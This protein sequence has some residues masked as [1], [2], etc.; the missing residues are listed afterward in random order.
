MD[1]FSTPGLVN[2]FGVSSSP[3]N[4]IV[5][6]KRPLSSMCL[7]IVIDG[8]GDV[9]LAIGSAGGSRIVTAVA[10]VIFMV[11][12]FAE[13]IIEKVFLS[14]FYLGNNFPSSIQRIT[15]RHG[16]GKAFSSSTSADV[17]QL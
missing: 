12:S 4:Y 9:K 11:I 16:E 13:M 1:D 15:C 5:P 14:N 10:Y 17:H 2:A 3:A 8:N 7:V 6:G